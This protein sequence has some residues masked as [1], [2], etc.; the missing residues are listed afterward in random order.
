MVARLAGVVA[1]ATESFEGYDYTRALD[2]TEEFFWW[3]CDYYLELVKGRR[4]DPAPE[5]A[6]SV[7]LALRTSL[8]VLQR[9]FAPFL[10]FVVEEV[11]SW[12]QSGSVHRAP[13][14]V[15]GELGALLGAPG[16]GLPGSEDGAART[17]PLMRPR[18][19]CVRCARRSQR[20]A[21]RCARRGS[22]SR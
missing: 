4:Y 14:P 10:P 5:A 7:S 12:W 20:G 16:E 6:A 3:Y 11:W 19:S 1:D 17:W 13:W 9:L 21:A 18:T 8:S 2:R 22:A 15:G